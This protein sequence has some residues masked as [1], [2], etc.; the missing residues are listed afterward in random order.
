M[1]W[2][3]SLYD[4]PELNPLTSRVIGCA[5]EVHRTLGAG[6]LES[7][8]LRC[9]MH[10]LQAASIRFEGERPLAVVYKDVVLGLGFRVD[11]AVER[12]VLV[13][14]KAVAQL[15]PV[16]TAQLL[17]YLRLTEY[18]VGLLIN[19]NV[20]VLKAGIRRV[21][22]TRAPGSRRAGSASVLEPPFDV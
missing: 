11:L 12:R 21:L 4:L 7:I 22:N 1:R 9:L 3:V 18:P 15:L 10:E 8:Y 19:F 16:H 14:V 20:P 17:T 13:E 5:L 2:S 6:L